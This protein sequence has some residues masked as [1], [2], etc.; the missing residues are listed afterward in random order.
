MVHIL[1]QP[2]ELLRGIFTINAG[3]DTYCNPSDRSDRPGETKQCRTCQCSQESRCRTRYFRTGFANRPFCHD[4]LGA[5]VITC[6]FCGFGFADSK[7]KP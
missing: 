3:N 2:V 7:S 6:G 4:V 5:F 1:G